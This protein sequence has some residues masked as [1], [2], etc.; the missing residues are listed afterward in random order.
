MFRFGKGPKV[1][2]EPLVAWCIGPGQ[3]LIGEAT[4]GESCVNEAQ[5]CNQ[6]KICSEPSEEVLEFAKLLAALIEHSSE[7]LVAR[8]QENDVQVFLGLVLRLT[9]W[10]GI[11]GVDDNISEVSPCPQFMMVHFTAADVS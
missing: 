7:W 10:D 3:T 9:G 4:G 11:G 2:T 8:I 5:G 6:T 1:L